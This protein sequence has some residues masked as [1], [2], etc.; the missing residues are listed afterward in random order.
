MNTWIIQGRLV[1]YE[2]WL[3]RLRSSCSF[4]RAGGQS[5]YGWGGLREGVSLIYFLHDAVGTHPR[6]RWRQPPHRLLLRPPLPQLRVPPDEALARHLR[7]N[8]PRSAG[9]PRRDPLHRRQPPQLRS[10]PVPRHPHPLP[11]NNED[12]TPMLREY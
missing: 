2:W 1:G 5:G 12:W 6:F 9:H 3:C 7:G 4:P 8:A 10:R 11:H